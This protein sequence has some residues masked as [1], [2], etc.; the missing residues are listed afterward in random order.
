MI[1]A[2]LACG[3]DL[4]SADDLKAFVNARDNLFV[5]NPS[6]NPVLARAIVRMTELYRRDRVPDLASLLQRMERYRE[7]DTGGELDVS[8][9]P[10]FHERDL[11]GKRELVLAKLQERLF[12][13]SRRNRLLHFRPTMQTL[14][15]TVASVPVLLD[16]KNIKP[17]DLL[18]WNRLRDAP[19]PC[20]G[21]GQCDAEVRDEWLALSTQQDVARF[22]I[23]VNHTVLVRVV[24]CACDLL[25]DGQ[26][27]IHT[28]LL[29]AVDPLPE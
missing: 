13:I 2:A 10:G 27:V 22:D 9:I 14:N 18:T 20:L 28:K 8:K 17:S 15:L 25:C 21:H 6:L 12:E 7:Q 11:S 3:V 23:A 5:L 26:G 19:G 24:E 16:F 4:N 1:L 29:L